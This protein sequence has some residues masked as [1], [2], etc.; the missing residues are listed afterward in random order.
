MII[1]SIELKNFR[2]YEFLRIDF[3]E[4][5]NIFYGDNAQGKT[6]ILESI[7]IA[8]TSKSQ[9][10]INE[11]DLIRLGCDEAHIKMCVRNNRTAYRIDIHLKKNKSKGIAID[12]IPIKKASELFGI[13]NVVCF[14]PEDMAL[15][16]DGPSMRRRF[17]DLELCQLDKVYLYNLSRYNQALNQ[18]NKLLKE[19]IFNRELEKTLPAWDDVLVRYGKE[20]IKLRREFIKHIA[21]LASEK[22]YQL[23]EKKESISIEYDAN[24]NEDEF[25]KTLENT[26]EQDIKHHITLVGPHRDDIKFYIGEKD[27]KRF[28]SQGQQRTAALA[29]KLSE[30]ELVKEKTGEYPILLLD[31]VLSELDTKRQNCLL[32]GLKYTQ[33]II[34]CTGLEEFI[35]HRFQIDD[36]FRVEKGNVRRTDKISVD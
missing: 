10:I 34:T 20:L 27:I 18:R 24:V 13:A 32:D 14:S 11:R 15:I 9:R 36:V 4:G 5:N 7:F 8:C 29:L 33:N 12:E 30:I 16:K 28:G 6:N 2:N 3:N 23:T 1:D 22:H 25:E 26:H 21:V 17:M 19:I 31:D 35:N